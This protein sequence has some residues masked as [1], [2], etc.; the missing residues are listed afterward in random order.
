[1]ARRPLR[2]NCTP[3]YSIFPIFTLC[4]H[5]ISLLDW[6]FS[7]S[8]QQGPTPIVSSGPAAGRTA[9]VQGQAPASPGHALPI[10]PRR[11]SRH[12]EWWADQRWR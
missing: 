10:L 12:G 2:A 7:Y 3:G 11:S 5:L 6:T 1:M 4:L 9:V 8:L